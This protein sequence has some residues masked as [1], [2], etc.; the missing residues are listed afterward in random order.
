MGSIVPMDSKLL[1]KIRGDPPLHQICPPQAENLKNGNLHIRE[2][3]Y[4]KPRLI[5][6]KFWLGQ[7]SGRSLNFGLFIYL[8]IN[9]FIYLCIYLFIYLFIY[10]LIK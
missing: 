4:V 7:G 10:L 5:L 6:G 9:L 1:T 8:L 2:K 3:S